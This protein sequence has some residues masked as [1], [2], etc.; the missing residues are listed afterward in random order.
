M[1]LIIPC[2]LLLASCTHAPPPSKKVAKSQWVPSTP[3]QQM[4]HFLIERN[5]PLA[6]AAGMDVLRDHPE[7]QYARGIVV[8]S[9]C[10]LGQPEEARKA[11]VG[12]R[13]ERRVL[14]QKICKRYG[15]SF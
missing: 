9:H 10:R 3:H 5:Y 11:F 6:I 4:R 15:V 7:D 8:T 14:A 1:R 2:F 13:G 12:L